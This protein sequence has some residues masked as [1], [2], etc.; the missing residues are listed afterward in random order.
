MKEYC[1]KL[2]ENGP[3]LNGEYY[4]S[5]PYNYM[6]RDGRKVWV[7]VNVEKFCQW[8]TPEDMEEYLFYTDCVRN[9]DAV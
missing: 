9:W 5:L 2:V 1:Q 6:V 3:T 8:G 4:A 7:P